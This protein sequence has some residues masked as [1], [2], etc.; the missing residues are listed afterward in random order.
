LGQLFKSRSLQRQHTELLVLVTPH[1]V[2]PVGAAT[3]TEVKPLPQ[4]PIPY[5]KT[6]KFDEKL[7]GSKELENKSQPATPREKP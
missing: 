7:P 5:M 4:V 3:A 2:D 1:I 6:P